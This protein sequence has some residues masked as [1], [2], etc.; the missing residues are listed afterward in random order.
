MNDI[1]KNKY[2]LGVMFAGLLLLPFIAGDYLL[3]VIIVA[4]IYVILTLSLNLLLVT[5]GNSALVG[6]LFME[7]VHTLRRSLPSIS[8]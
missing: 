2:L 8:S 6:P 3:R 1:F 4:G 5:L 7:L